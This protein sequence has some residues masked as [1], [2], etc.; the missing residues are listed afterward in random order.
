MYKVLQ[1]F[2]Y[3]IFTLQLYVYVP[4]SFTLCLHFLHK[5]GSNHMWGNG[6]NHMWLWNM[7]SRI[8]QY[9][10]IIYNIDKSYSINK[11]HCYHATNKQQFDN[12][13]S[14]C[15]LKMYEFPNR[16]W[17]SGPGGPQRRIV[18]RR[19][20]YEL[21]LHFYNLEQTSV[22]FF[23]TRVLGKIT[24]IHLSIEK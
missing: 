14:C 19:G 11:S 15:S 24:C 13:Y 2:K 1:I 20:R 7:L 6:N 12:L 16:H 23:R 10:L 4:Y 9:N 21:H 3:I 22:T 8:F 17:V 18:P 5:G